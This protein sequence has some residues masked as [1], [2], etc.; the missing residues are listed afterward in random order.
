MKSNNEFYKTPEQILQMNLDY[1]KARY[2]EAESEN[3]K[4][5]KRLKI[6]VEYLELRTKRSSYAWSNGGAYAQLD[7]VNEGSIN[8]AEKALKA[9][10]ESFILDSEKGEL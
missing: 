7:W 6:A 8:C 9:I 2:T 4:L 1:A 3:A 10:G 5:Q